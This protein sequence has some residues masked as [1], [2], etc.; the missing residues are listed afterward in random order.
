M[1]LL[2]PLLLLAAC[3]TATDKDADTD[4][5]DTDAVDSDTADTADTDAEP[6]TLD[7]A[8]AITVSEVPVGELSCLPAAGTWLTQTVDASCIKTVPVQGEVTDF[9]SGDGVDGLTVEMFFG[10]EITGTPDITMTS[11][12]GGKVSGASAPTC[13][14]WASRVTLPG[15]ADTKPAIQFHWSE[16]F[17]DPMDSFYNSVDAGTIQLISALLGIELDATKGVVAGTAYDCGGEGS[18][19]QGVQVLARN[20]AGVYPASQQPRYFLDEFPSRV[21]TATSEDGLWLIGGLEPGDYVVEMWAVPAAGQAARVIG[22]TKLEVFADS[23][24]IAD[25]YTGSED[26]VVFPDECTAPCAAP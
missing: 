21:A 5:V 23:L 4:A 10:D 24:T 14:A 17:A 18:E 16:P 13:T 12:D 9:E 8:E 19:F 11:A 22:Q 6:D 3:S 1:R 25:V 20:A 7:P 26:G 15:D 2:A